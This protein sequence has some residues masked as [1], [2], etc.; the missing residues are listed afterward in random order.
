MRG[1]ALTRKLL[2]FSARQQLAAELLSANEVIADLHDLLAK[3]V[4]ASIRVWL[5]LDPEAWP[6]VVDRGDLEDALV[7]LALNARDAMPEG[8]S[9]IIKTSNRVVAGGAEESEVHP[10]GDYLVI[11]VIDSG[12]G[13]PAD[14]LDHAFEPFYTTKPQGKGTG[15]GLSMV[16]GFARGHQC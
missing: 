14:V 1:G 12:L 15:L 10:A 16:Y 5:V 13:M 8:G 2:G 9:L 11:K 4:T 3:S 7:N 6:V